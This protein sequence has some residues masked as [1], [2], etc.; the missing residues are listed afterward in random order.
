MGSGKGETVWRAPPLRAGRKVAF[1]L[2][3]L[4]AGTNKLGA[5]LRIDGR[6]SFAEEDDVR[7]APSCR[8]EG[9]AS[10]IVRSVRF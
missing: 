1:R 5:L 9:P 2:T 6:S 3:R 10:A 8:T 4:A 7:H